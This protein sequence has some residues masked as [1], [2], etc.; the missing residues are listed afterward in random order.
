MTSVPS[1]ILLVTSLSTEEQSAW[2]D[3]LTLAMPGETIVTADDGVD[4]GLVEVAIVANP[5]PGSLRDLPALGWIHSLWAGV[6][7]ILQ[8]DT[9]PDTPI[10]RLVD[11]A[12]AQAMAEGVAA[13]VLHLHRDLHVYAAQQS[14]K[15]W[16]QHP[17]RPVAGRRVGVLGL[18]EMGRASAALLATLGFDVQGWSRSK[19]EVAK[20][21]TFAGPEGFAPAL[22]GVEILVNLLP[23]TPETRGVLRRETFERLAPGAHVVNFGRGAHLVAADLM[24]ALTAGRLGHAMLDVFDQEPLPKDHPLWSHPG[25]T[26]LPHVAAPTSRASAAT[27]VAEAI[28]AFRRTGR[29][30][31]A[32]DRHRGY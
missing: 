8:D 16:R 32:I 29:P 4:R 18:G 19:R 23:L 7:K 22:E 2:R 27:I 6:E 5:P 14:Q 21:R 3:I 30:P 11:P 15:E 9:L 25:V 24:D 31:P 10:V 28:A 1:P 20:V 12:L 26:I 13:A 17:V